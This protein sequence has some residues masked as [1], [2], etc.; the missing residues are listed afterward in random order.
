[1]HAVGYEKNSTTKESHDFSYFYFFSFNKARRMTGA[2]KN[3][4]AQNKFNCEICCEKAKAT[5]H[6]TRRTKEEKRED[7][8]V[9]VDDGDDDNGCS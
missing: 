8:D 3:S 7:V 6:N 9:A 2:K 5:S 4:R 1:M